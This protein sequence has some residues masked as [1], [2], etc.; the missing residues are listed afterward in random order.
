MN[1]PD[2]PLHIGFDWQGDLPSGEELPPDLA[3]VWIG[4]ETCPFDL[5]ST[6]DVVRWVRYIHSLDLTS[7]LLL[8]FFTESEKRDVA[9]LCE[10]FLHAGGEEI[11]VNDPN[12]AALLHD[13][14]WPFSLGRVFF[15]SIIDPRFTVSLHMPV[16]GETIVNRSTLGFYRSL[17]ARRLYCQALP[18]S[19]PAVARGEW[20]IGIIGPEAYLTQSYLCPAHAR[21]HRTAK[22]S[23]CHRECRNILPVAWLD[24]QGNI[25]H[26]HRNAL[27]VPLPEACGDWP[28]LVCIV[29]WPPG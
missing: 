17:G 13:R 24:N 11:V 21:A 16:R 18:Q 27:Y 6:A 15:R 4:S 26:P 20:E 19:V 12:G 1:A 29:K 5:P 9:E 2:A 3:G 28:P 7:T 25:Y 22:I 10:A 14:G 23:R 8:P